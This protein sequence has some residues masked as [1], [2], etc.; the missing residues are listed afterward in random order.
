M[1]TR[2]QSLVQEELLAL[3]L[4]LNGYFVTEF[5][6][7]S[8]T[9]GRNATQLDA[10]AVRHPHSCEPERIVE[11]D[12][13]LDLRH[14]LVDLVIGEAKNR[15]PMR[16]NAG[17]TD[18][19]DTLNTVL[20]WAGLFPIDDVECVAAQLRSAILQPGCDGPPS[21]TVG[22]NVRVRLLMFGL[23]RVDRR[24]NQPWFLTGTHVL[25]YVWRC[26]FATET[27]N[28]CSTSYDFQAWGRHERL[29]RHF[30]ARGSAGP[31]TMEDLYTRL[32]VAD[33]T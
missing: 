26:L 15:K 33:D 11:V 28:T 21:V 3:Y 1:A 6:V 4:R 24:P 23:G 13:A 19:P 30:K 12:A 9:I 10:L 7:H 27:R 32:G 22:R 8:G 31:G 5:I 2:S 17:L 25:N 14:D 20:R 29:V 18:N 16:P